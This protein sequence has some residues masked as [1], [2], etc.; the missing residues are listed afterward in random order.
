MSFDCNNNEANSNND[1]D[2]NLTSL[3]DTFSSLL[4]LNLNLL[5][6]K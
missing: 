5:S 6:L 2:S 3:T 1:E 4:L